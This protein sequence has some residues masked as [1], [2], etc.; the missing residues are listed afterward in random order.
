[1]VPHSYGVRVSTPGLLTRWKRDKLL[2]SAPRDLR[3]LGTSLS[4][5]GCRRGFEWRWGVI[6]EGADPDPIEG[7]YDE[8]QR[9]L[10]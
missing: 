8:V 6:I 10:R 5:G 2:R 1:V 7:D 3:L 9:K 4:S